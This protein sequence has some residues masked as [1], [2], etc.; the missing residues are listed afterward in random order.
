MDYTKNSLFVRNLSPQVN[1]TIIREVFSACDAIDK[2][3]FKPFPNNESQFFAQVDFRT[4]AGVSEGS[5]LSGTAILGVRCICGVIDP[6]QQAEQNRQ[7]AVTSTANA[8]PTEDDLAAQEFEMDADHVRKAKEAAEETRLKTCHIAGLADDTS[9]E[10]VRRL[11]EGF[12]PVEMLRIDKAADG[13]TFGLVEFQD[14]KVAHVVK[15]Q[16]SFL[17]EDRVLVF[18]EA[19]SHVDNARVEEMTVKFQAP[20]IDA[21]NMR[22]VLSQQQA[23]A[24]KLAKVREAASSIIG[25]PKAGAKEKKKKEKKDK[26]G[27]E[28]KEKKEK[29]DKNKDKEK[30]KKK[31]KSVREDKD[32]ADDNEGEKKK[33]PK[34]K[35]KKEKKQKKDESPVKRKREE[36]DE[37]REA[38]EAKPPEETKEEEEEMMEEEESEEEM[39][40]IDEEVEV[41]AGEVIGMLGTSSSSSSSSDYGED[42]LVELPVDC[43]GDD[44]D[45]VLSDGDDVMC[46]APPPRPL[47]K[48]RGMLLLKGKGKGRG[49]PMLRGRGR[50]LLPL[51]G[52]GP[53]LLGR[54][55]PLRGFARSPLPSPPPA[56]TIDLDCS[57]VLSVDAALSVDVG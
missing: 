47:G 52:R 36:K 4:S 9:E 27:K 30:K 40:D 15:M 57:A 17:V 29:K 51:R 24:D 53:P 31:D 42:A 23:L 44:D 2:V 45:D 26:T 43:A 28:K 54:G 38:S 39:V 18:T 3:T 6:V 21:M 19:K 12:G 1:E 33:R 32:G 46:E 41:M 25:A 37:D 14:T 50:G 5:K 20:I 49:V 55:P 16:R 10:S 34:E 11:C 56:G 48:G 7:A 22:S 13:S 35:K 8:Q